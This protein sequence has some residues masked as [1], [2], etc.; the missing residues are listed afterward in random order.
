LYGV[1]TAGGG[2]GLG[3]AFKLTSNGSN[4][5]VLHAFTATTGDAFT[6]SDGGQPLGGLLLLG[7]T[8]YGT[9]QVGGTLGYGTLFAVN[10]DGTGFTN[11]H[12]FGD[13]GDGVNPS[14][15]LISSGG[16]L[17][18]TASDL[19]FAINTNGSGYTHVYDFPPTSGSYPFYTNDAGTYPLGGL[20]LSGSALFG[21]ASQGGRF[22]DGTLFAVNTNGSGFVNIYDFSSASGP[23]SSLTNWDGRIPS[24]ALALSGN[25]LYGTA[26]AGGIFSYGTAFSLS[27]PLPPQLAI[28]RSAANVVLSWATNDTRFTLESN[29]NLNANDWSVVAP[30]PAVS[31]TNNVV[32]NNLSG[33]TRFYRL[34]RL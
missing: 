11:L 24:G 1:T 29:T 27:L 4:L 33:P 31:G 3:T 17:Y 34:H 16:T 2:A 13:A 22:G 25:T 28:N 10:T 6:N 5:L 12:N 23:P 19:V 26:N 7:D 20:I 21:T 18:G 8:I 30:A 14:G 15:A 9:A 32:T